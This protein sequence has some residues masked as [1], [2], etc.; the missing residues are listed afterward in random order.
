MSLERG[1]VLKTISCCQGAAMRGSLASIKDLQSHRLKWGNVP[2]DQCQTFIHSLWTPIWH[3]LHSHRESCHLVTHL[4][5]LTRC[6][7]CWV[8]LL[9]CHE[10]SQEAFNHTDTF[11]MFTPAFCVECSWLSWG[12]SSGLRKGSTWTMWSHSPGCCSSGSGMRSLQQRLPWM[13]LVPLLKGS[14]WCCWCRGQS[15]IQYILF[16]CVTLGEP[17]GKSLFDCL[18]H[19]WLKNMPWKSLVQREWSTA[20]IARVLMCTLWVV[21]T[22]SQQPFIFENQKDNQKESCLLTRQ[23]YSGFPVETGVKQPGTEIHR[24]LRVWLSW[25]GR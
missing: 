14:E 4:T 19:L 3:Q 16:R 10:A 7:W 2:T 22:L 15:Q 11:M 18:R 6:R 24:A 17:F 23:E 5:T 1:A 21:W 13:H 12:I 9:P 25:L 8:L 20:L